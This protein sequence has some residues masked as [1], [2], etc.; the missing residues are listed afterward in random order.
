MKAM[1]R[2]LSTPVKAPL[3]SKRG[4]VVTD[5]ITGAPS[6]LFIV[7]CVCCNGFLAFKN[8]VLKQRAGISVGYVVKDIK[9]GFPITS[10][11]E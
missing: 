7:A 1:N 9:R 10:F 8:G 4:A 11:L 6:F 3:L 5:R 2:S